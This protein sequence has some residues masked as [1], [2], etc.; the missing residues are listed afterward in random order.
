MG[1][2]EGERRVRILVRS[3]QLVGRTG[4][5]TDNRR[6]RSWN[7]E[8]GN[9]CRMRWRCLQPKRAP[10]ACRDVRRPSSIQWPPQLV[11]I[12]VFVLTPIVGETW[13]ADHDGLVLELEGV[14]SP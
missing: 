11:Y 12:A 13:R 4:R 5:G 1:R 14:A 7:R 2:F 9:P 10:R 3:M 6:L 8:L